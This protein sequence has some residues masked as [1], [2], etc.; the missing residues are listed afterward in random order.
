MNIFRQGLTQRA[1]ANRKDITALFRTVAT[2]LL[3]LLFG[4]L[5]LSAE[6]I[7]RLLVAV[8]GTV[9]T[10]G[11]LY[12]AR[13]LKMLMAYGEPTDPV[14]PEEV[15]KLPNGKFESQKRTQLRLLDANLLKL[16][17]RYGG[18]EGLL[19][20]L[21]KIGVQESELVSFLRL[22]FSIWKFV[23]FRF[24]PFAPGVS[25]KDI[26]DHYNETYVPQLRELGLE[27]PP[28]EAVSAEIEGI[29]VEE[30]INADLDQWIQDTRRNSRIEYFNDYGPGVRD[31]EN[32]REQTL[33]GEAP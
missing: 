3:I 16:H 26:E 28:L 29:L 22:E 31:P 7:D 32:P 14:P 11:D 5:N 30:Q 17:D 19:G 18:E 8:N 33:G 15:N 4:V 1:P 6:E 27:I 21:E 10:E 9:I 12:I 20:Q 2:G 13:S 23:E 24:Q 25:A